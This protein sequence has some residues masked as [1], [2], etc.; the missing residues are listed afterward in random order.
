VASSKG[1]RVTLWLESNH[2]PAGRLESV[3]FVGWLELLARL[4]ELFEEAADT[5][6]QERTL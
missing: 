5:P 1:R 2:P 4:A 3:T 6:E